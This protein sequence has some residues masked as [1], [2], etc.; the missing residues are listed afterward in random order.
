MTQAEAEFASRALEALRLAWGDVYMF[1]R[2][3]RGYWAARPAA[4][5]GILSAGTPEELGMLCAAA[6]EAQATA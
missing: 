6:F 4:G 2:D 5:S 1:G 3:E